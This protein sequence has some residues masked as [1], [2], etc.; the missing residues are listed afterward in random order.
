MSVKGPLAGIQVLEI[1]GIGPCPFAAMVLA[2]LGADVIRVDRTKAGGLDL[3]GGSQGHDV[4]ARSRRSVALDLKDPRGV[5]LLMRL[6]DTADVLIEGFRPGVAERLGIGPQECHQINPRL[7]YGRMTGWGQEGP[8]A[9]MAGH[10]I[11]YIALAGALHPM[12]PASEPPPVP[13]N[14]IGDFGGGGMLLVVGVLAALLSR[15][16]TGKGQVVDAAMVDGSVLLTAM[17]HGMISTGIWNPEAREANVLDGAAPFYRNYACADGQYMAVGALEPQFYAAFMEGLGLDI[18]TW[19]QFDL[20]RWPQLGQAVADRFATQ[21]RDHWQQ[22]FDGT[23]A[24]VAPVLGLTEAAD[25]PHLRARGTF[26]DVDGVRQPA[27]APRFSATPTGVPTSPPSRGAHTEE[28]LADL[29]YS[30]EEISELKD[31]GVIATGQSD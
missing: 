15:T 13:L 31:Q 30:P 7:V 27:P 16:T 22:V 6:V 14:L 19:P 11:D 21:D 10:D 17:F 23:D 1:Q 3:G 25:H 8:W 18:Q 20:P 4:L 12:G 2:D 9:S 28:V 24:C 29:G 5:A 26:V